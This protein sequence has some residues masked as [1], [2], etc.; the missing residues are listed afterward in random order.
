MLSFKAYLATGIDSKYKCSQPATKENKLLSHKNRNSFRKL[1]IFYSIPLTNNREVPLQKGKEFMTQLQNFKSSEAKR[2]KQISL[3][4]PNW[5][6]LLT[7]QRLI[8]AIGNL[9]VLAEVQ[10]CFHLKLDVP[11]RI[12]NS[13]IYQQTNSTFKIKKHARKCAKR[14][15]IHDTTSEF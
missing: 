8:T 15:R 6:F 1:H 12:S 2:N 14:K 3:K 7:C 13:H 9:F 10:N 4:K 11:D 5:G